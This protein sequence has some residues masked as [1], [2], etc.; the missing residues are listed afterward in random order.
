MVGNR[1][2]MMMKL[3]RNGISIVASPLL[4]ATSVRIILVSDEQ[5]N[6]VAN[7]YGVTRE[8][9]SNIRGADRYVADTTGITKQRHRLSD[10]VTQSG[11]WAGAWQGMHFNEL[12]QARGQG[13]FAIQNTEAN[14]QDVSLGWR[15]SLDQAPRPGDANALPNQMVALP[16]C[17]AG[18]Y[19]TGTSVMWSADIGIQ[20]GN[21]HTDTGF[22]WGRNAVSGAQRERR[23]FVIGFV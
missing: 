22:R 20:G 1:E 11:A 19:G 13:R 8:E 23:G 10:G 17:F 6:P 16:A 5:G 9:L 7:V 2:N 3:L 4:S 15:N 14:T 21:G 18:M 12:R